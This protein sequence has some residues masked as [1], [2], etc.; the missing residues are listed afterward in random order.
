M[1]KDKDKDLFDMDFSEIEARVIAA[2]AE[3]DG[4]LRS[5]VVTQG[6]VTGRLPE[7]PPLHKLMQKFLSD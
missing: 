2:M 4:R 3:G 7:L 6:S 5:D 1:K